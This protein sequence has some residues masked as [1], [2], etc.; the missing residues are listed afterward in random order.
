M[1]AVAKRSEKGSSWTGNEERL[2]D[3]VPNWGGEREKKK[4]QK[5]D[6]RPRAR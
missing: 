1:V 3:F 5:N 4:S 2:V 6:G